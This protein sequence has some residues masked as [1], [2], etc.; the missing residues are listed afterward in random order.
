[1]RWCER[2]IKRCKMSG[3]QIYDM[4]ERVMTTARHSTGSCPLV[5]QPWAGG[6]HLTSPHLTKAA[7][8]ARNRAHSTGRHCAQLADNTYPRRGIYWVTLSYH[9]AQA[10]P[11]QVP[12]RLRLRGGRRSI[13]CTQGKFRQVLPVIPRAP[14]PSILPALNR[15]LLSNSILSS[16]RRSPTV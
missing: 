10:G 5:S 14:L 8:K 15:N 9:V 6:P 12:R 16:R 3:R 1:M 11:F 13:L 7:T 2:V 4:V